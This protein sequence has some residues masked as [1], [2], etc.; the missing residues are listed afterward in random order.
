MQDKIEQSQ[1]LIMK[2]LVQELYPN[3]QSVSAWGGEDDETPVYGVVKIAIK[4][5]SGATLTDTTKESI[6]TQ[7]QKYNVASVRPEIVDP[8][9][10][11]I[12]INF[13]C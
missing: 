12:I 11:S 5:A 7:L 10:T 3:A 4:A 8:E 1:L 2:H 13:K 9:T 6:K